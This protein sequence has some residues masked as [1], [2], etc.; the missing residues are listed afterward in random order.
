MS[1]TEK[2]GIYYYFTSTYYE[3]LHPQNNEFMF[4]QV[5]SKASVLFPKQK[6]NK[7]K[8]KQQSDPTRNWKQK[9]HISFS[10][11]LAVICKL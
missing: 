5:G 3:F 6:K 2:T 10:K 9:I 11:E 4:D 1:K 7:N 8:K